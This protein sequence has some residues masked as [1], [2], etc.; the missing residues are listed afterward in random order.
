[1]T[2]LTL[3]DGREF[4]LHD[5]WQCLGERCPVHNPSD[6]EYRTW[7]HAWNGKHMLRTNG[8][9][10]VIDPDDF[11]FRVYGTAILEN[12]VVCG[13]CGVKVYS[14]YRHDYRECPC[15]ETIVDGG[16][17][18]LRHGGSNFFDTSVVVERD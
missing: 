6:H 13:W 10:T 16:L 1:M 5:E 18:Y 9:Q 17:D 14:W 4:H 7:G 3:H 15:G 2:V 11:R 8:E 12:S